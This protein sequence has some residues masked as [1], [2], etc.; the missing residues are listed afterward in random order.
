[1]SLVF[2]WNIFSLKYVISRKPLALRRSRAIDTF[3]ASSREVV[4]G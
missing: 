4:I 1:M 3:P 2:N